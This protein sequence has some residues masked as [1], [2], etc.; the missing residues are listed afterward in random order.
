[1]SLGFEVLFKKKK[2]EMSLSYGILSVLT[3]ECFE[4]LVSIFSASYRD[5][6]ESVCHL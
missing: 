2:K 5:D 1:M 4:V 3:K 6:R